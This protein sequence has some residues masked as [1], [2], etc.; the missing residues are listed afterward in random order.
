MPSPRAKKVPIKN[1]DTAS[2]KVNMVESIKID[3][4][5]DRYAKLVLQT[6][7]LYP[8]DEVNS[9]LKQLSSEAGARGL[10]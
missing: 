2:R 3:E 9:N 6:L 5:G 1:P 7:S 10:Y 8:K 4:S